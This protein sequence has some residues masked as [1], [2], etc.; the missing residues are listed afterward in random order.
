[1]H[2][3][4]THKMLFFS[5]SLIFFFSFFGGLFFFFFF[6]EWF[7]GGLDFLLCDSYGFVV[8][9]KSWSTPNLLWS[10][11]SVPK[12]FFPVFIINICLQHICIRLH[13]RF[14]FYKSL[15][16]SLS[17]FF[18]LSCNSTLGW[19]IIVFFKTLFWVNTF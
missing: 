13:H 9:E 6:W 12:F 5:L 14:H 7:F 15:S 1:M 19:R 18:I 11:F 8:P 16:L 2:S 3:F 4:L 10:W 17:R